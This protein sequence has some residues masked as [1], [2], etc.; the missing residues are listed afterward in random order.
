M[1]RLVPKM[2][3]KINLYRNEE[4]KCSD[5]DFKKQTEIEHDTLSLLALK[6]FF[7]IAGRWNKKDLEDC[8]DKNYSI[9]QTM[10]FNH[11]MIFFKLTD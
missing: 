7:I 3:L 9:F 8:L 10:R 5:G 2:W 11:T 6:D 4:I 1:N